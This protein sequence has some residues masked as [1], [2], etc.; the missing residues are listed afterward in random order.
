MHQPRFAASLRPKPA[1]AT[2]LTLMEGIRAHREEAWT[3][4][5]YLYTPLVHHWCHRWGVRGEDA[6]DIVQE[7]FQAVA[8][9]MR[10]FRYERSGDTFRGWLRG[11]TRNKL[12]DTYRRLGQGSSPATGGADS[13]RMFLE[14]PDPGLG[15][16]DDAS[17]LEVAGILRRALEM[18][19]GE[20]EERS[21]QA[22]WRAAVEGHAPADIAMDLGVSPAAVR[23]SKSRILRRLKEVMGEIPPAFRA[24]HAAHS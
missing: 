12:L 3:R 8:L 22:F 5:L 14:V 20:F 11:I 24:H 19:R 15:D 10:T 4:L 7:V 18:V 17:D 16:G 2:S 6:E 13:Y 1:D 21:W 9:G 23:Q